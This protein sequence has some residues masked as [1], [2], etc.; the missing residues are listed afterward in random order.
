MTE[1]A[2]RDSALRCPPAFSGAIS[3]Q[4][5]PL[6]AGVPTTIIRYVH[7]PNFNQQSALC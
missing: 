3:Q 1:E 6:R 2:D 5:R 7:N 4:F